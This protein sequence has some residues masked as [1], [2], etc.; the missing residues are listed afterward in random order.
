MGGRRPPEAGTRQAPVGGYPNEAIRT[1][2]RR[3][4]TLRIPRSLNQ[5][6]SH[7]RAKSCHATGSEVARPVHLMATTDA[8]AVNRIAAPLDAGHDPKPRGGPHARGP[9]QRTGPGMQITCKGQKNE[10]TPAKKGGPRPME[11]KKAPQRD[12]DMTERPGHNRYRRTKGDHGT[13]THIG[14][15]TPE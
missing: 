5:I 1:N 6:N 7:G 11:G 3:T 13:P 9:A 14:T 15:R 10:R 12:K 4:N 2:H 8:P